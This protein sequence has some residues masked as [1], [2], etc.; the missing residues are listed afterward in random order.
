MKD[1][2]KIKKEYPELFGEGVEKRHEEIIKK[3]PDLH[4]GKKISFDGRMDTEETTYPEFRLH[5]FTNMM[6][7]LP[8]D[9]AEDIM[10]DPSF[11]H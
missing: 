5:S 9:E 8:D 4:Q 1:L 10:R 6:L 3:N 2:E 7:Y 11:K